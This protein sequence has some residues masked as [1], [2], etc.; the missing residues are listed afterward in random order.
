[1]LGKPVIANVN[2][3]R[4]AVIIGNGVNGASDQSELLVL[5]LH[6][7][8]LIKELTTGVGPA[9]G[10]STPRGWDTDRSGTVDVLYAG[11]L[12]GNVWKFDVGDANTNQWVSAL[13]SGNK[14]VPL[15]VAKD[16]GGTPQP[17]TGSLSVGIN[18]SGFDRWVFFG[19]GSY[20]KDTDPA[21][22]SVQT[23]YGII[24]NDSSAVSGRSALKQRS[25]VVQTTADGRVYRAFESKTAGD[26]SGKAGWYVDLKDPDGTARGERMVT[27]VTLFGSV[28]LASSI[29]PSSEPCVAGGSGF[30]NAIDAFTGTNV[31]TPFF[32][33]NGDGKFN[34]SDK[35]KNGTADVSVGSIDLGI[36]M[37]T[38]PLVIDK[39]LVANGTGALGGVG[40]KNPVAS[41]RIA[42]REILKD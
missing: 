29:I 13:K 8:A 19:T 40:V 6:T 23:W 21:S 1:V 24:D 34:A 33:L 17:I 36:G 9:N 10:M 38:T 32:D 5:D 11:D 30:I 4:S 14:A 12:L 37:P 25:T 39:I 7:G 2:T 28:L 41:G 26:M 42:W 31:T 35:I 27:G 15:F 16:A 18:P 20:M 22:K 3:G